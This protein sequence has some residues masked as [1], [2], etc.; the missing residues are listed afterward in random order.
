MNEQIEGRNPVFEALR[1]GHEINKIFAAKG[2]ASGALRGILDLAGRKK[3][4]VSFVEPN[5]LDKMATTRNHQGVIAQ[6]A[7]WK[8][9]SVGAILAAAEAKR[10]PPFILL[11][12]GV[13]DPQNLGSILR[14]AE[15]AGVHG[16]IIPERRAAGLNATVSR[17]SAGAIEYIPVARVTNL[18]RTIVELKQAGLWFSG[19]VMDGALEFQKADLKGPIG[20]VVGG[21]GR[22]ISRL[23]AEHCDQ[24]VRLPM[25]GRINSLNV[26]VATGVLLY[27]IRRQRALEIQ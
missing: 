20:L 9:A 4:P 2:D 1:A 8:Y 19:A 27:E 12:D 3:I 13:E 15:T 26:S 18:S 17:A 6:A 10:E 21:E 25:W 7:S 5:V 11:L 23:V 14:T 22:G 24:M 16:I